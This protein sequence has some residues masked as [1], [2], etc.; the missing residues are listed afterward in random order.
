MSKHDNARAWREGLRL[1][2]LELSNKI[3]YSP[4]SIY[5]MEQGIKPPR[6]TGV[7]AP[8]EDWV[9]LRYQRACEG[10]QREF[11]GGSFEW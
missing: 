4:E 8:V 11:D 3:G 10:L 2:R 1:T 9:W 7:R 6:Q 5:W